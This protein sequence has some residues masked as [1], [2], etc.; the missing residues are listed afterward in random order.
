M[1]NPETTPEPIV[2]REEDVNP[3]YQALQYYY[4]FIRPRWWLFIIIP[5]LFFAA[6]L[7]HVETATPMY[8]ATCRVYLQPDKVRLTNIQDVYDVNS[9]WRPQSEIIADQI[10]L[11]SSDSVLSRA[12]EALG[13][14]EDYINSPNPLRAFAGPLSIT[15]DR[16]TSFLNISYASSDRKKAATV[17]NGIARAYI[18]SFRTRESKMSKQGL[19]KLLGSYEM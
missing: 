4:V 14:E 5:A 17:A 1:T 2:S 8:R 9:R 13:M 11:A 7:F 19:E 15:G 6:A 3:V 10:R 12:L 18:D 16:E